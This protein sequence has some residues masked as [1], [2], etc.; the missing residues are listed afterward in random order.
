MSRTTD[1]RP[2]EFN[3]F[4]AGYVAH[5]GD[6]GIM[7]ALNESAAQ[8]TDYLIHVDEDRVSYAYAPG[9]WTIAQSLQHIIDTERIFSTR[10]LRIA[11]GDQTPLPGY[12]QNDYADIADVSDRRF[13]DMIEEFRTVRS[14]TIALFKSFT[15][16]DLLR[17][18]T[19]SGGS[20]SVRALGFIISGH[21]YHHAKLYTEK[22]K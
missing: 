13:R 12:E 5:V 16:P 22:Y 15:E 20:A 21:V 2:D 11:R 6:L 14:G 10:A 19:V 8:L 7:T 1:L 4:Y 18:G 17:M 3:A 9:K